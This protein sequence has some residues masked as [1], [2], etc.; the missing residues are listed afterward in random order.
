MTNT[1]YLRARLYVAAGVEEHLVDVANLCMVE[2]MQKN[3]S[4]AHFESVDDG[5]HVQ[6]I[7]R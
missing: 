7:E 4:D 2:Y 3:H 1:E 5:I 6:P